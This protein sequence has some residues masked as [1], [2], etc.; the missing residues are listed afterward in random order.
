[1]SSSL[2]GFTLCF[3]S[4]VSGIFG[5]LLIN[6]GYLVRLSGWDHHPPPSSI[7][8]LLLI[9]IGAAFWRVSRQSS[10]KRFAIRSQRVDDPVPLVFT[11][12]HQCKKQ[13]A[14]DIGMYRYSW[15]LF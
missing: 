13:E 3:F 11:S 10:D 12:V 1:V 7:F 2:S 8:F 5:F 15:L 4:C 14:Q 9:A 6:P